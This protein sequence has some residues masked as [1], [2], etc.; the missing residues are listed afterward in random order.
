MCY[1]YLGLDGGFGVVPGIVDVVEVVD[2]VV[3][4][5][6]HVVDLE[7]VQHV[8]GQG[9]GGLLGAFL[10]IQELQKMGRRKECE[11]IK[12]GE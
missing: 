1:T 6:A 12:G 5:A 7:F 11:K 8:I 3:V 9:D 10:A 2:A 4:G